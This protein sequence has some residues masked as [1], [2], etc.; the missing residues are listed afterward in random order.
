MH[1]QTA[2]CYAICKPEPP[3]TLLEG[4]WSSNLSSNFILIIAGKLEYSLILGFEKMLLELFGNSFQVVPSNSYIRL[5]ILRVPYQHYSSILTLSAFLAREVSCNVYFN[6]V[7][8]I[9]GPI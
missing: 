5:L 7:P 8:I 1:I 9:D 4:H 2:L 3:I 6:K